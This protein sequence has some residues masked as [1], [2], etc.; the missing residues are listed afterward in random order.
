MKVS[1]EV[2]KNLKM[3]INILIDQ[4]FC[5]VLMAKFSLILALLCSHFRVINYYLESI[6]SPLA[7][8]MCPCKTFDSFVRDE[9][10]CKPEQFS[11]MG[12]HISH[13]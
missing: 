7:F 9:C 4:S 5:N 1:F 6:S 10:P 3:W 8:P 2:F 13:K 11:Y 12:E